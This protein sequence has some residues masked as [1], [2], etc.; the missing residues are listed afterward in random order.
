MKTLLESSKFA[1][2]RHNVDI[3]AKHHL[4]KKEEETKKRREA[5]LQ[6][7]KDGKDESNTLVSSIQQVNLSLKLSR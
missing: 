1:Y 2:S 5:E 7:M 6:K 3:E 4:R